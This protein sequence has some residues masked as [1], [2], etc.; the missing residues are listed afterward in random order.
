MDRLLSTLRI[1]FILYPHPNFWPGAWSE[2]W[3]SAALPCI[4]VDYE[5]KETSD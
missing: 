2:S 5:N 3:I 1:T 4:N